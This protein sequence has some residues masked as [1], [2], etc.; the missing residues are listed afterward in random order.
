MNKE[1]DVVNID[2]FDEQINTENVF[3]FNDK[4]QLINDEKGKPCY[5]SKYC[6]C[7]CDH[8][9]EFAFYPEN[10]SLRILDIGDIKES[11]IGCQILN[12]T[13]LADDAA[14]SNIKYV[15]AF[16]EP[17]EWD[18]MSKTKWK[19]YVKKGLVKIQLRNDHTVYVKTKPSIYS[20]MMISL[21]K[22]Y[23]LRIQQ[24]GQDQ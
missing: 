24:L 16:F 21:F 20:K 7:A 5:H 6:K 8:F 3:I 10:R 17:P 11:S 12:I 23:G 22:E 15:Y 13:F 18:L 19:K 14:T 2:K 1:G 4:S 9:V